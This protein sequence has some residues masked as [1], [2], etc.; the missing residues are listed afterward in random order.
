MPPGVTQVVTQVIFSGSN[1][2]DR[3]VRLWL[4]CTLNTGD[5]IAGIIH[6]VGEGV[7]EFKVGDR[8]TAFDEM[9]QP[10]GS[11]AG[12]AVAC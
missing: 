11:Y 10:G 8:V 12:Y 5:D 9:T 7:S 2:K 6:E 1:P 4:N 3:K